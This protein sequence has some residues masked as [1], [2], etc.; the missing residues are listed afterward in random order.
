MFTAIV[1]LRSGSKGIKN[2]NLVSFKNHS[3]ANF[4]IKKL[5]KIKLI[6]KIYILTDSVNY[7][8]K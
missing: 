4:T 8:K 5:L 6:D 3:L 1:P 7:K 2:K